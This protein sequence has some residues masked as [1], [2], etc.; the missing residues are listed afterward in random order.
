LAQTNPLTFPSPSS[1]QTGVSGLPLHGLDAHAS[2]RR[3]FP[4]GASPWNGLRAAISFSSAA[5]PEANS[6][7]RSSAHATSTLATRILLSSTHPVFCRFERETNQKQ[8]GK[9]RRR[10]RRKGEKTCVRSRPKYS[11]STTG[12]LRLEND[13]SA[14]APSLDMARTALKANAV[15]YGLLCAYFAGP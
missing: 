10:R 12:P 4:E 2:A 15:I 9:E 11:K 7:A 3:A 13:P 8:R 14:M 6:A 1:Q 5:A